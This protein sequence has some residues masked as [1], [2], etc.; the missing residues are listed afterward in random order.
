MHLIG[1]DILCVC[2]CV[3]VCALLHLLNENV[4]FYSG[5]VTAVYVLTFPYV[6]WHL[7]CLC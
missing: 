7:H 4:N 2:V 3:C 6:E 1:I 5:N